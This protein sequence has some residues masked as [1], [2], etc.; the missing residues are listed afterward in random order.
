MSKKTSPLVC[1]FA[2]IIRSLDR[3]SV[4]WLTC[5]QVLLLN[6]TLL[7]TL[8]THGATEL[9]ELS[10]EQLMN[11][12]IVGASKYEQ[13][14]SEVAAAVSVIT[15]NEIKTF[16]WHTLAEA[17]ASLPGI[18]TT[19]ER[20]Y[21]YLGT[22]GFGL[23]GDYN[24]RFLLTINGNRVNDAV[25]DQAYVGRDFPLDMDLIERIEFIPGPGGAIYGQNGISGWSTW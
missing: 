23:P 24:T 13:K 22:R 12:T 9:T 11:V 19:Y 7:T 20:Q 18:Y 25:Y 14:Q 6:L 10:L 21:S 16:G 2:G 5:R 17:L 3:S 4:P 1:Q 15:R 8:P